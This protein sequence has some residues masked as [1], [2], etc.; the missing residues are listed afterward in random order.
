MIFLPGNC[1]AGNFSISPANWKSQSASIKSKWSISYWFYDDSKAQKK[2]IV[3]KGMNRL[4]TLKE[5][6]DLVRSLVD[7]ETDLIQSRGWN[8]ITKTFSIINESEIN[9][10]T[11]VPDAL[12]H[13]FSKIQAEGTT[14]ASIKSCLKFVTAAIVDLHYDRMHIGDIR[15]KH[16]KLILDKCGKNAVSYNHYRAYLIMLFKELVEI[17]AVDSNPARDISKKRGTKRMRDELTK[18]QRKAVREYLQENN[19]D[20]WTF[21]NIFFHSGSRIT[22]L[23]R[24]KADQVDIKGQQFKV[25]IKKGQQSR[26]EWRPIKDIAMADWKKVMA[27][28][29]KTDYL[30]SEGLVPGP[31]NIRPEQVGRRWKKL[32]RPVEKG[33]LGITADLYSL[34]HSNL[35]ETD[36]EL[37]KHRESIKETARMA[38][39]TTPIITMNTY[40]KGHKKRKD[41]TL[42]GVRNE[43]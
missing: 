40:T 8:H 37:S 15:R 23:L 14:K 6:Q 7:Y 18:K 25:L 16:L 5:R 42:K 11:L 17:E 36:A 22:E 19:P 32:K 34:K 10:H 3:I 2:K 31:N 12:Q 43:F 38:G 29:Q 1:R 21:V 41:D 24:V 20:F 30:F 27:N 9:E 33:G 39:H 4:N 13:A 26:E 28:A 35:D